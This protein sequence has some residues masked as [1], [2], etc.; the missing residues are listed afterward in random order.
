MKLFKFVTFFPKMSKTIAEQR[1]L[2][3]E[4][5]EH[6]NA[7]RGICESQNSKILNSKK[8][9]QVLQ[10]MIP[11]LQEKRKELDQILQKAKK[12]E[13]DANA[14]QSQ[15]Y[16][17][18]EM[19]ALEEIQ[20]TKESIKALEMRCKLIENRKKVLTEA[21]RKK[22]EQLDIEI[23]EYKMKIKLVEAKSHE[24]NER[25]NQ[26]DEIFKIKRSQSK[27]LRTI[28]QIRSLENDIANTQREL[29]QKEKEVQELALECKQ[30][31][32]ERDNLRKKT[33]DQKH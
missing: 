31:Q 10:K 21:F 17:K 5:T 23:A 4:L 24:I 7:L 6:R 32:K 33:Q 29:E 3:A 25:R 14:R 1:Q 26:L 12:E 13:H 27:K 8:Q 19:S 11:T 2:L 22:D 18:I 28:D 30:L 20:N 15:Q 9:E 16:E